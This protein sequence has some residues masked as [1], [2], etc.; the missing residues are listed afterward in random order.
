MI[1][2]PVSPQR[3]AGLRVLLA[4]MNDGPGRLKPDNGLIPFQQFDT[5]HVA[6]LLI[7]DDKTR[8]DVRLYGIA[9]RTYPLYLTL[10]GDVDGDADAFLRELA[11]RAPDGLRTIFSLCEGFTPQTDL[12]DWMK[13][14][15]VP[16]AASYVNWRGR[17]VQ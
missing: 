17:T 11:R 5:L 2:A 16:A 6:R 7:V 14:H 13:T 8:E 9:P 10:L 12:V 15:N 1:L 4:S 3:E